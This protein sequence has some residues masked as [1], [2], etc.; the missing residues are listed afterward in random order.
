M[1]GKSIP[2]PQDETRGLA[3][4][5]YSLMN[6]LLSVLEKNAILTSQD[7]QEALHTALTT[8]EHRPQDDAIDV[9]RRL[10]EGN[11]ITRRAAPPKGSTD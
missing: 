5:S 10:I 2:T 9:A 1:T 11:S 8:L 3:F 4:A 6:G 7:I